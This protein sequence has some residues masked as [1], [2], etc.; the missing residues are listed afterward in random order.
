VVQGPQ[1]RD[2]LGAIRGINTFSL[3]EFTSTNRYLAFRGEI[4][5]VESALRVLNLSGIRRT[6]GDRETLELSV[7]LAVTRLY[8]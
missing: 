8:V 4:S 1:K 6:T 2:L 5:T 7:V 3:K